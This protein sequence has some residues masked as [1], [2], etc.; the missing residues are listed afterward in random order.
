MKE[1]IFAPQVINDALRQFAGTN[2]YGESIW[3]LVLAQ[4]VYSL[5][6]GEWHDWDESLTVAER[7]GFL[8]GDNDQLLPSMAKP[9]QVV[10]EMRLIQRYIG[11]EGWVLEKWFHAS[12][13]DKTLWFSPEH[14]Q[15]DGTP[16]LGPWPERGRFVM[17]W[18]PCTTLPAES[19]LKTVI[20]K[21]SRELQEMD[22]TPE[23]RTRK[24]VYD[25]TVNK[26]KRDAKA[27]N[28][29]AKMSDE[30]SL[31]INQD[32][33]LEAARHRNELASQCGITE[34]VGA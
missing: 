17:L 27:M 10:R 2:N 19:L 30:R 3:R 11:V 6:A 31:L 24:A 33:S 22:G 25:Y 26:R 1:P 7:G 13:F 8:M 16:N 15:P 29:F 18:G 21:H 4:S 32:S 23:S 28:A 12:K 20:I 34:H 5:Q 9:L 14:C